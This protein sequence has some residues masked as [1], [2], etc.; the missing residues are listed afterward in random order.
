MHIDVRVWRVNW[1]THNLVGPLCCVLGQNTSSLHQGILMSINILSR[2]PDEMLG[3]TLWWTSIPSRWGEYYYWYS[4]LIGTK[5]R[6]FRDGKKIVKLMTWNKTPQ[7]IWTCKNLICNSNNI[8]RINDKYTVYYNTVK[9][10]FYLP[11]IKRKG[12]F[13]TKWVSLQYL[14]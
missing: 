12:F 4:Y 3:G 11:F 13:I 6:V 2:K 1:E 5:F 9:Y 14:L 8:C 10:K 7:G